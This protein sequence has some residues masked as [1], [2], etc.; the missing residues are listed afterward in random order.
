MTD[1]I[2]PV[3][4]IAVVMTEPPQRHAVDRGSVPGGLTTVDSR[5]V[6]GDLGLHSESPAR[7]LGGQ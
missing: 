6:P 3:P 4:M 5:G 2:P 1:P 7:V